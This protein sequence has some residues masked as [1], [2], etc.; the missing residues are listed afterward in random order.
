[1][2]V[3]NFLVDLN[4]RIA[5]TVRRVLAWK[6]WFTLLL[7]LIMMWLPVHW[8]TRGKFDP[9]YVTFV[10]I[11]TVQTALD[12]AAT[13]LSSRLSME[14]SLQVL[15]RIEQELERSRERDTATAERDNV[16]RE[17]VQTEINYLKR[18]VDLQGKKGS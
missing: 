10:M 12:S 14:L 13:N 11:L 1:V 8:L 4:N 7:L 2:V 3:W 15:S 5:E 18:L 6:I 17:M 16:L 9:E